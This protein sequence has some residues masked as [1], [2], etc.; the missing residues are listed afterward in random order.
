MFIQYSYVMKKCKA[1]PL[2]LHS[3]RI[4][5]QDVLTAPMCATHVQHTCATETTLIV[6]HKGQNKQPT[7]I[8]RLD[9][10]P[11]CPRTHTHR[12]QD[13]GAGEEC[14]ARGLRNGSGYPA[15]TSP[16]PTAEWTIRGL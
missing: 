5:S 8:Q 2:F 12:R 4:F 3:L 6:R 14:H 9:T 15:G 11:L 10:V 13:N 7:V 16:A 1:T